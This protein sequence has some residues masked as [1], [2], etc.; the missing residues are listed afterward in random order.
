MIAR[1]ENAS[2]SSLGVFARWCTG[3]RF[4]DLPEEAVTAVRNDIRDALGCALYGS[5]LPWSR[6][7]LETFLWDAA[8]A[9]R[10]G[11]WGTNARLPGTLASLV[12]ASFV[13]SFELDSMHQLASLHAGSTMLPAVLALAEQGV[14]VVGQA[15]GKAG[16]H[17]AVSGERLFIAMAV[18]WELGTR[19]A[20]CGGPSLT[21]GWHTPTINGTFSAAAA[22]GV[23]LGLDATRMTHCLG[24][25]ALQASG[26]LAVQYGGDAK[27]LYAGKASQAGLQAALLAARGYSA[28]PDVMECAPGGLLPTFAGSD[29]SFDASKLTEGLGKSW[30]ASGIGFKLY[31]TC[32]PNLSSVD[33]VRGFQKTH[34][35]RVQDVESISA[36]VGADSFHHVGWTYTPGDVTAAQFSLQYAIAVALIEGDAFVEQY[37]PELM[38]DLRILDMVKRISI[39]E[40]PTITRQGRIARN[41]ARLRVVLKS[42]EVLQNE[43]MIPRG[44]ATNPASE[45][46]LHSK[47]ERLARTA[48]SPSRIED[49]SWEL[50]RLE[51]VESVA[52]LAGMLAVG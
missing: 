10:A 44:N 2:A 1:K 31:A 30:A 51:S 33:L 16:G 37:R 46:E 20:L 5:R 22:A 9:G 32:A 6:T 15:D 39:V 35:L 34:G 24:L 38:A 42:G 7:M 3:L 48:L 17:G 19:V 49:I 25:A 12:N 26:I 29:G 14:P 45:A 4:G 47:F 28:P 23:A 8:G 18:G 43:V 52:G 41:S 13:Q 36:H 27:R 21:K 50:A 11:V 40:D